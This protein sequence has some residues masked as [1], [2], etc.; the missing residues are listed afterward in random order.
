M[1]RYMVIETF[2]PGSLDQIYH[3]LHTKGRGLPDGLHFIESWLAADGSRCFQIMETEDPATF[4][5]WMPYWSDLVTFDIV[6]L[7]EKPAAAS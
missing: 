5:A 6:A 4:D 2:K 7:G 3:R 1:T